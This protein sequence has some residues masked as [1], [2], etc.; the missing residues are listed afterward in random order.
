LVDQP[1]ADPRGYTWDTWTDFSPGIISQ[2]KFAYAGFGISDSAPV[3]YKGPSVAAQPDGT[4]GCIA[5]PNGGLGPM[6][7]RT[8][9]LLAPSGAFQDGWD[10]WITGVLVYGVIEGGMG[11]SPGDELLFCIDSVNGSH[12]RLQAI[13][14]LQTGGAWNRILRSQSGA[15]ANDPGTVYG[16]SAVLT[17]ANA[18]DATG[19]A[20][21]TAVV[22]MTTAFIA[23]AAAI[24]AYGFLGLYPDPTNPS[25]GSAPYYKDYSADLPGQPDGETGIIFGHQGR[26]VIFQ[27]NDYLWTG[28]EVLGGPYDQIYY[29]DPANT[30]PGNGNTDSLAQDVV[31]VQEWPVGAGAWGSMSAGELFV[32]KHR[33]G[34]YIV[35]G[36]LNE[37]TVTFLGGVTPA[38]GTTVA[39]QTP[40]GLVYLSSNNGC[41]LWNGSNVSQKLSN[42]LNDDFFRSTPALPVIGQEY[43][44]FSWVD[45]VVTSNNWVYDTVTG[46]WWLLDDQSVPFTWFG[47]SWDSDIL[48]AFPPMVT[49][50]TD[51]ICYTYDKTQPATSYQWT[52]QPMARSI[53]RSLIVREVVVRAQGFGSI[54]VVL[55]GTGGTTDQSTPVTLDINST[56]QPVYLRFDTGIE[57]QDVT[58]QVTVEGSGGTAAPIIYGIST[59]S[60]ETILTNA[61]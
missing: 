5:L 46:G 44:A 33:G 41:W 49:A 59:A 1:K 22:A 11:A 60:I 8:G 13:C 6:P 4:F 27:Q 17:M 14:A 34:G 40:I 16:F 30:V 50:H 29:T 24:G 20:T 57:A 19:E 7:G 39:C 45:M 37:P 2:N 47:Q 3:P 58:V 42:Q 15:S 48:Y 54:T 52:S 28:S 56:T 21:G 23:D 35:S 10:N 55:Q 26:I 38:Y 18:S 51:P 53:F 61:T 25:K 32:V 12:N 36:D 31:F 9:T 43:Q